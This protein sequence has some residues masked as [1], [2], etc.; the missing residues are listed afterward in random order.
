VV[1]IHNGI[2]ISYEKNEILSFTSKW[3]ELEN[4][5]LSKVTQAQKAKNGM[6]SLICGL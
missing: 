3:I 6:L 1:F 5:I 2:L 4:I